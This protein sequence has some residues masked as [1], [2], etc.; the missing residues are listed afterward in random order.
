M[1]RKAKSKAKSKSSKPRGSRRSRE[2]V[3]SLLETIHADVASGATIKDAL[4]KAGV[5]YSNYNY[6]RKR[7]GAAPRRGKG[8]AS[9]PTQVMGILQEMTQNRREAESLRDKLAQLDRRFGKLKQQLEK[10]NS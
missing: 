5:S 7:E 8:G 3:Q 10:S 6:W 1:P 2:E 9:R 4:K